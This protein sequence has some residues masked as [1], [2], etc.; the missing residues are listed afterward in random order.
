MTFQFLTPAR[1]EL[2]EAVF[3][4]EQRQEGLGLDFAN[5]VENAIFRICEFPHAYP[6]FS[7]KTRQCSLKRFPYHIVY[8][9]QEKSILII[10]IAHMNRKPFYWQNRVM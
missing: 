7:D 8:Q 3:F 1:D 9:I 2:E 5:H 6:R 4:Y 10:A